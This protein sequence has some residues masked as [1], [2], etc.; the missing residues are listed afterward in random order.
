MLSGLNFSMAIIFTP[1]GVAVTPEINMADKRRK[2]S[3]TLASVAHIP[4]M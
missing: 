4:A 2:Y 3:F 1:Q